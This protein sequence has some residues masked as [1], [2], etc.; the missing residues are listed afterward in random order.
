MIQAFSREMAIQRTGYIKSLPE[1]KSMP[2]IN[3]PGHFFGQ[4][5]A[6]TK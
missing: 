5:A 3:S 6:I 4:F 2:T 1:L